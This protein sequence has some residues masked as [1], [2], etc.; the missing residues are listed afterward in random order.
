MCVEKARKGRLKKSDRNNMY[1]RVFI[2]F[3]FINFN[4]SNLEYFLARF[5]FFV[6]LK[7]RIVLVD[8]AASNILYQQFIQQYANP[9]ILVT[10]N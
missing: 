7:M 8:E 5:H 1:K 3:F 9:A 2:F 4:V 10:K 6:L